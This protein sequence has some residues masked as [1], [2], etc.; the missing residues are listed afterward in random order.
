MIVAKM[1]TRAACSLR[2]LRGIFVGMVVRAERLCRA[3]N[4]RERSAP[5]PNGGSPCPCQD[6]ETSPAPA[7]EGLA[8]RWPCL[9]ALAALYVGE[10]LSVKDQEAYENHFMSCPE[11]VAE[12][13]VWRA[14]MTGLR[15]L[16]ELR[17]GTAADVLADRGTHMSDKSKSLRDAL[18]D[19]VRK[20]G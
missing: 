6:R 20:A 4:R 12:V 13:E 19:S 10:L 8:Q 18:P 14:F 1:T 5:A 11:C 15:G 2:L 3:R 7:F 16:H 17:F 9:P